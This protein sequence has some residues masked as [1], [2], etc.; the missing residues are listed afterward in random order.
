MTISGKSRNKIHLEKS[1]K[2]VSKFILNHPLIFLKR[3][4]KSL[5]G[6]TI[7]FKNRL[8]LFLAAKRYPQDRPLVKPVLVNNYQLFVLANESLGRQLLTLHCFEKIDTDFLKSVIK[9]NWTCFDV[10]ANIGYYTL[11]LANLA[12]KGKVYAFEPIPLSHYL[13][14]AN[15]TL[16][17]FTNVVANNIALGDKNEKATFVLPEDSGFASFRDTKRKIVKEKI[18]VSVQTLDS[19]VKHLKIKRIDFVKIDV[20]GAERLVLQGAKNILEKIKPKILLIELYDL[21]LNVYNE[22]VE[23][24]VK[25]LRKY[26]YLPYKLEKDKLTSFLK[27]DYNDIHNV[28]FINEI[29]NLGNNPNI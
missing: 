24:I 22:S 14:K 20:E 29:F 16:N 11:L 28:Y 25:F 4:W 8:L 10:G 7:G 19:Y 1:F 21:N 3:A 26:N 2:G 27:E 9:K 17:N 15:L 18:T 23:S 13:L 6:R 12:P 5:I